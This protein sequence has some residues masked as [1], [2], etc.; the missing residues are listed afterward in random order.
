[1]RRLPPL[2]KKLGR[3]L[4][5]LRGQALS[6]AALLALGVTL[7]VATLGTRVALEQSRDDYYRAQRLAD[8]QLP[9]VRAPRAMAARAAAVPGVEALEARLAVPALLN[10]S[11]LVE[12]LGA[13]LLSLDDPQ[14][15][16]VNRPWL[17]AG[18]WPQRG[19][20]SRE[21]LL[22]EAFA[23]ARGIRPGDALELTVRGSRERLQVVGIANSP[24]FVFISPPGELMPIPERYA[25][26]WMPREALEQAA[27]LQG[28]FNEVVL[29]LGQG[30]RAE[31][32]AAELE[33][34]LARHG[35]GRA[36][37]RT[38]IPSS[39]FLDQELDQLGTLASVL[40]PAFLAVAA[41]LLNL[42]LTRLVEAERSTLGLL[43][44]FG[45]RGIEVTGGYLGFALVVSLAGVLVGLLAGA[46]LG[47]ELC[48]LYLEV[49]RLPALDY[50]IPPSIG[51]LA[52]AVGLG[53]ALLGS[54]FALRRV[55]ALRPAEALAPPPP[56][57][58]RHGAG[59]IESVARRFDPLT[60]VVLRRLLGYPR[61]ALTTI[62]GLGAALVLLVLSM[63]APMSIE[64]LLQIS[65]GDAKRQQRTVSFVEPGGLD[66]RLA[67]AR[68]PGVEQAEPFLALDAVFRNGGRDVSE[69]IFGLS[70]QP[71]FDRLIDV[72]GR[73]RVLREDGLILTRGLATQLGA[74]VGDALQVQFTSGP[75]RAVQ[76]RVVDVV[77][78]TI[79][80]SA[81]MQ[82]DA[83]G[84]LA[85]QPGRISGAHLRLRS[86]AAAAFDLAV[87]ETPMIAGSSDIEAAFLSTRRTFKEGS[88][89][90]TTVFTTFAVLMAA[91]IAFATATVVLGEQRRDLATLMVLGYGR[92]EA[93]YVLLAEL[94]LLTLLALPLGLFAGHHFAN[95]FLRAMATDVF[96]FPPLFE[97]TL[98]LRAAL[99]TL[100]SVALAALWVRRGIDRIGLVE[101][102]KSRE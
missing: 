14:R 16:A 85:G 99:I 70:A 17:A 36:L 42:T 30:A 80:S 34:L 95:A 50:R 102:L 40:P 101:S 11:G 93:S 81:Y 72:H 88:G 41:F 44:A 3:D 61:R 96:T 32:V 43:K 54:G 21:A 23:Q 51:L 6:A 83:L 25:V 47:R 15:T 62:V 26:V 68:L 4:L 7:L 31:R 60:R 100:G 97:P 18:R 58:F 69:A 73:P 65:F 74:G 75:R 1:M 98:H 52:F 49:Y 67:L 2:W 33:A 84:R 77:D 55:L 24:E 92:R 90:M 20:S 76:V 13:R 38:R 8:L 5:R 66:A 48:V 53:A 39:R 78:V 57:A 56:P 71:R 82:I 64:R 19:A 46:W 22:N 79:G 86:D 87:R 94:A 35:A 45:L 59:P 29:R 63:Q 89:M 28:A 27:G 10:L 9:L 12:P 37:D 91:G